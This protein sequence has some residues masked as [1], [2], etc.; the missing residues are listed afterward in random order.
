MLTFD[1][2]RGILNTA[3][4][5]APPPPPQSDDHPHIPIYLVIYFPMV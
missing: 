1:S 5:D 2:A 3:E 4:L